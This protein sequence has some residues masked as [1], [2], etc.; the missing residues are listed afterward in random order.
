MFLLDEHRGHKC[1]KLDAAAAESRASLLRLESA[2]RA[3]SAE[4]L[5]AG[6]GLADALAVLDQKLVRGRGEARAR[7]VS[8]GEGGD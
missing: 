4:L 1:I 6:E 2:G 7:V 5:T 8:R 3:L